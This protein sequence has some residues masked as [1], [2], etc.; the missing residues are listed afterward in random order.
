MCHHPFSS[1]GKSAIEAYFR[2]HIM[3]LRRGTR[4]LI[5][6]TPFALQFRKK[7]TS[8]VT[9]SAE[10]VILL[11]DAHN[12]KKYDSARAF[13]KRVLALPRYVLAPPFGDCDS[14]MYVICFSLKSLGLLVKAS[15][16]CD[17]SWLDPLIYKSSAA[18]SDKI[19]FVCLSLARLLDPR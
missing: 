2:E 12:W 11:L 5:D 3:Q 1:S 8:G 9:D 16:M 10:H 19:K 14:C 13:L 4:L 15:E 6:S 18:Y 17:N 7:I